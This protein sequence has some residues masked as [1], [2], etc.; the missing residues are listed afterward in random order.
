MADE[1]MMDTGDYLAV[2]EDQQL[3]EDDFVPEEV[4]EDEFSLLRDV[5]DGEEVVLSTAYLDEED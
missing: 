5:P 1:E 3:D 4:N 2:P